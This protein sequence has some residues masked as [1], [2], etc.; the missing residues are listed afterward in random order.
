MSRDSILQFIGFSPH[1][2]EY[3]IKHDWWNRYPI[4]DMN[5]RRELELWLCCAEKSEDE[6]ILKIRCFY[7]DYASYASSSP[8]WQ[9]VL[10]Q[11]FERKLHLDV[12]ST[13]EQ[14]RENYH[15]AFVDSD[16]GTELFG[17]QRFTVWCDGGK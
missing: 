2:F 13:R 8:S 6:K 11:R 16:T 5:F 15:Y 9:E 3:V 10:F 4:D 7:V 14:Q 1:R 12:I 17:C